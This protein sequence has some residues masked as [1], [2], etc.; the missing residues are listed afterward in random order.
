MTPVGE[1]RKCR[2]WL[3]ATSHYLSIDKSYSHRELDLY[4]HIMSSTCILCATQNAVVTKNWSKFLFIS[5]VTP[6]HSSCAKVKCNP[7]NTTTEIILNTAC[8]Q[9][10]MNIWNPG[11]K[12]FIRVAELLSSL[13]CSIMKS[14]CRIFTI[15]HSLMAST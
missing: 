1:S 9:A 14:T 7:T 8:L 12:T 6:T 3:L 2:A 4:V 13:L 11:K 15:E 10:E 5:L